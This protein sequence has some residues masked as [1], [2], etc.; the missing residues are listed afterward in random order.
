MPQT[1]FAF[2]QNPTFFP[3]LFRRLATALERSPSIVRQAKG[4]QLSL[5]LDQARLLQITYVIELEIT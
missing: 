4:E 2:V 5:G 1:T 3:G